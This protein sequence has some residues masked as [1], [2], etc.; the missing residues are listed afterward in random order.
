MKKKL[1][2]LKM[3]PQRFEKPLIKPPQS[4]PRKQCFLLQVTQVI[5]RVDLEGTGA[6]AD[7]SPYQA[8]EVRRVSSSVCVY[9]DSSAKYFSDTAALSVG[10]IWA[11]LQR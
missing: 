7:Y 5:S 1:V 9:G 11:A 6:D 4:S 8:S 2:T 3:L 10:R